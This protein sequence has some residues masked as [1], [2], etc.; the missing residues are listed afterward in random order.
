MKFILIPYLFLSILFVSCEKCK[1][2]SGCQSGTQFI[3]DYAVNNND[4]GYT[5]IGSTKKN[6]CA[7]MTQIQSAY[8]SNCQISWGQ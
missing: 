8:G 1:A 2:S 3:L 4:I 6:G 7:G 5:A